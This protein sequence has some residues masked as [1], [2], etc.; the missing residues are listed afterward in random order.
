MLWAALQQCVE[1]DQ[2][3]AAFAEISR[4][5]VIE[6]T[7]LAARQDR[8]AWLAARGREGRVVDS[9]DESRGDRVAVQQRAGGRAGLVER[10]HALVEESETAIGTLRVAIVI[11]SM[12]L[13]FTLERRG[14]NRVRKRAVR[15][16]VMKVERE[17]QQVTMRLVRA[18]CGVREK[19]AVGDIPDMLI[20]W[21]RAAQLASAVVVQADETGA[22]RKTRRQLRKQRRQRCKALLLGRWLGTQQQAI[23][24][25]VAS[26]KQQIGHVRERQTVVLMEAMSK[27]V[28]ELCR[29]VWLRLVGQF[30]LSRTYTEGGQDSDWQQQQRKQRGNGN[31]EGAGDRIRY[32]WNCTRC[33]WGGCSMQAGRVTCRKCERQCSDWCEAGDGLGAVDMEQWLT[34]QPRWRHV[35]ARVSARMLQTTQRAA[36]ITQAAQCVKWKLAVAEVVGQGITGGRLDVKSM[37]RDALDEVVGKELEGVVLPKP[38]LRISAEE[39]VQTDREATAEQVEKADEIVAVQDVEADEAPKAPV[40]LIARV[41]ASISRKQKQKA[42]AVARWMVWWQGYWQAAERARKSKQQRSQ[43]GVVAEAA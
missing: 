19:G 21:R 37:V 11:Q 20:S 38:R 41:M 31:G 40:D 26:W 42:E 39:W 1:S 5:Q 13:A 34:E 8:N 15:D 16:A 2:S 25:V 29:R 17:Q 23:T 18:L 24:V 22:K 10:L 30:W 7:W 3:D 33:G 35:G 6:D 27:D 36:E 43:D 28:E 14:R 12:R 4:R 9:R 32:D